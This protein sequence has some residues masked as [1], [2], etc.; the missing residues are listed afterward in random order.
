T[1]AL[2]ICLIALS[3]HLEGKLVRQLDQTGLAQRF[4]AVLSHVRVSLDREHAP[5]LRIPAGQV[6][7]LIGADLVVAAGVESL[8]MLATN[9]SS[10]IVNTHQ[11]M[12][13]SFIRD[14]D[15]RLPE[16][17]LLHALRSRSRPGGLSTL[18]ATRLASAL[19]GDSV[20]ANV[21]MLG[22]A[23]QRG[24]LPV[25]SAALY[26]ALELFGVNV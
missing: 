18:D 2:P 14:P 10:V 20:A 16:Q 24:K 4:G 23:F 17:R 8:A 12:P 3:A 15:Y 6:D 19:L 11:E 13:P 1:C 5:A 26:R 9:R 22:F 21:F 25:G 7:L